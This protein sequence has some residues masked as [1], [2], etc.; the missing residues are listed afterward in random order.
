MTTS[1]LASIQG[2]SAS[3]YTNFQLF[4]QFNQTRL[5]SRD[6]TNETHAK[7]HTILVSISK[8]PTER[9][10]DKKTR[11]TTFHCGKGHQCGNKRKYLAFAFSDNTT[12]TSGNSSMIVPFDKDNAPRVDCLTGKSKT[13]D[14]M[15]VEEDHSTAY[16]A[17][18]IMRV[19]SFSKAPIE[20]GCI[21]NQSLLHQQ[22]DGNMGLL[23]VG[24]FA[25]M[26]LTGT[27][28]YHKSQQVTILCNLWFLLQNEVLISLR[29][30]CC[31]V[32]IKNKFYRG[33]KLFSSELKA[34][35][36]R[37]SI[38]GGHDIKYIDTH[39]VDLNEDRQTEVALRLDRGRNT[40]Q[41]KFDYSQA[42]EYVLTCVTLVAMVGLMNAIWL[43]LAKDI[44][45][46]IPLIPNTWQKDESS[47]F[48][49]K[50]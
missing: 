3:Q 46:Q 4:K 8:Q 38:R 13:Y 20:I 6:K 21:Y 12:S 14:Q 5:F 34:T 26:L 19:A 42:S 40:L 49:I 10:F 29:S 22:L 36:L 1:S 27:L 33:T 11:K 30:S 16:H 2:I 45:T 7:S 37:A 17:S 23:Q 15:D 39:R 32:A 50:E 47:F 25:N 41:T 31:F 18:V 44:H 48:Q 35:V 9:N 43:A 24:S 28:R